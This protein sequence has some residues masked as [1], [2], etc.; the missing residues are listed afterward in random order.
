MLSFEPPRPRRP[1]SSSPSPRTIPRA[2]CG[3]LLPVPS[4]DVIEDL[5]SISLFYPR[6]RPPLSLPLCPFSPSRFHRT[7]ACA[8]LFAFLLPAPSSYSCSPSL[9]S[10]ASLASCFL[11]FECPSSF[12]FVRLHPSVLCAP[13]FC[14]SAASRCLFTC[15]RTGTALPSLCPYVALVPPPP[16]PRLR[17]RDAALAVAAYCPCLLERH[18]CVCLLFVFPLLRVRACPALV[19]SHGTPRAQR[20]VVCEPSLSPDESRLRAQRTRGE[21]LRSGGKAGAAVSEGGMSGS[22]QRTQGRQRQ[23]SGRTV[24]PPLRLCPISPTLVSLP[25]LLLRSPRGRSS[26]ARPGHGAESAR[27]GRASQYARA[28]FDAFARKDETR[29]SLRPLPRTD[30]HRDTRLFRASCVFV[31]AAVFAL[32]SHFRV[33]PRVPACLDVFPRP[34]HRFR[35]CSCLISPLPLPDNAEGHREL[36]Q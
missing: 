30:R 5:N 35:L 10:P 12:C 36:Q 21:G 13:F 23:R 17:T 8:V 25:F 3:W 20:H 2:C 34:P 24:P 15:C 16:A 7:Q 22:G 19:R 31:L 28:G 4:H 32:L 6:C 26:S 27:H 9:P 11:H 1:P 33:P 14:V 18:G 29:V